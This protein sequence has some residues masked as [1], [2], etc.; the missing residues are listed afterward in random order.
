M[1]DDSEVVFNDKKLNKALNE[2]GWLTLLDLE[3]N[4]KLLTGPKTKKERKTFSDKYALTDSSVLEEELPDITIKK[5][6]T[7]SY[8]RSLSNEI[9]I[10]SN[11][12]SEDEELPDI[13]LKDKKTQSNGKK[14]ISCIFV[15]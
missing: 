13:S 10:A 4:Q 9:E 15:T 8:H 6:T 5:T 1:C 2:A 14:R 7:D 3:E 12:I 11:I